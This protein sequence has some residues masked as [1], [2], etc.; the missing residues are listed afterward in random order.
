MDWIEVSLEGIEPSLLSR[1]NDSFEEIFTFSVTVD[2]FNE[3]AA[4]AEKLSVI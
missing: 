4:K 1:G 2:N 3:F